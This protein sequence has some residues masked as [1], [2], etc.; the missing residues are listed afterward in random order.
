MIS[1][2]NLNHSHTL[3]NIM[4]YDIFN[5]TKTL[6]QPHRLSPLLSHTIPRTLI[7]P[8]NNC[9]LS[10]L[11]S[12]LLYLHATSSRI[13][14][15]LKSSIN[16]E[17]PQQEYNYVVPQLLCIAGSEFQKLNSCLYTTTIRLY[18]TYSSYK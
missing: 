16:S 7:H 11:H 3:I 4:I 6:L 15:V 10:N 18:I 9:S 5:L 14:V 13:K 2:C 12:L 1:Y 8:L 17:I